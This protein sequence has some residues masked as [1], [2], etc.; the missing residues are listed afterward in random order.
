MGKTAIVTGGTSN[1]VVGMGTLAL[2]I[3]EKMSHLVDELII[4]HN[5]ISQKDQRIINN[6]FPTTFCRYRFDLS[7]VD[8]R[9]NSYIRYFSPMVFCKYECFRL[10]KEYERVIWTD[11]DVVIL[12]DLAELFE[13]E[14]GLQIVQEKEPLSTRFIDGGKCVQDEYDLNKC[15]VSTPLFVLTRNVGNYMEYYHWCI[16]NTQKYASNI[17]LP[18][19]CII[20]MLLQKFAIPYEKLLDHKYAL[21]PRDYLANMEDVSIIHAYGR[22]KFWEGLYVE[23]WERYYNEWIALGG[24][25]YQMS[26]KRKLEH[27]ITLLREGMEKHKS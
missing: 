20:S 11:Y 19:Q 6:I 12:K 23:A 8:K 2:N 24:S 4:F 15:G 16:D 25:K 14:I 21:H 10:L 18:E 17:I 5:G 9:K 22:P 27:V 3:K 7:F 1:E 26:L 13:S